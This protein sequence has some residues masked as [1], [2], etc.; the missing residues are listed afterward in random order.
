MRKTLLVAMVAAAVLLAQAAWAGAKRDLPP[1]PAFDSKVY[2]PKDRGKVVPVP[3]T[4]GK[5]LKI[6]VIGMEISTFFMPVKEGVMEAKALLAKENCTV[7]WIIPAGDRHTSDFF[8]NTIDACL[9]QEYDAIATI[10]GD[11]GLVPYINRAVEAGVPVATWNVETNEPN[12][13]LFFVGA[14]LYEQGQ[15][16]G[17]IMADLIGGK[18]KIAVQTGFFSVEGHELRRLGFEETVLKH[19]GVEIVSRTENVDQPENSY[20][21]AM[22]ALTANP[23]LAGL[24]VV[25]EGKIGAA[26]ALEETGRY[27]DVKLICFDLH[28]DMPDWIERGI[29]AAAIGQEANVQGRDP[30]IRLYNYIVGGVVPEAGRLF[31]NSD[32]VTKANAAQFK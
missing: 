28:D 5:P 27:K 24:F 26:R 1:G 20:T 23:D 18:G 22:D 7:D 19:P 8:G 3:N 21:Q 29:V 6:A 15:T 9:A 14:D 16:A 4:T 30:A 12:K 31:T 25:A 10:A 32:V 2:S 17:K 11:S 13:R